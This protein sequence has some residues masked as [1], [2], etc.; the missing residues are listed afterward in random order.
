M[1]SV[2]AI[3]HGAPMTSAF[4]VVALALVGYV[5]VWRAA[6]VLQRRIVARANR[7]T[8]LV[9]LLL[10]ANTLQ[11]SATRTADEI[12]QLTRGAS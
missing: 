9:L 7:R 3:I 1:R 4:L 10:K 12:M 5:Y 8:D 6:S 2:A 11:W